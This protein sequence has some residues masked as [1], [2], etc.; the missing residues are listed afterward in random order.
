MRRLACVVVLSA[1]LVA[2]CGSHHP[3]FSWHTG[4]TGQSAASSPTAS[5]RASSHAAIPP[6]QPA[7][8]LQSSTQLQSDLEAL[9]VAQTEGEL[10]DALNGL[11]QHYQAVAGSHANANDAD[12]QQA[13]SK[14][15]QA[16]ADIQRLADTNAS[17]PNAPNPLNTGA[18]S[19]HATSEP[20]PPVPPAPNPV[21]D[22]TNNE[23]KQAFDQ[24]TAVINHV[25]YAITVNNPSGPVG[26]PFGTVHGGPSYPD[27]NCGPAQDTCKAY[28]LTQTAVLLAFDAPEGGKNFQIG[29]IDSAPTGACNPAYVPNGKPPAPTASCHVTGTAGMTVSITPHWVNAPPPANR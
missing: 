5:S 11:R 26:G 16:L 19:S 20:K 17:D 27:I 15:Q 1:I 12:W 6:I 24:L 25:A 3:T 13:L 21:A 22:I 28:V 8:Q 10:V 4:Q 2:G 23:I 14:L 18:S 29:T 9:H 7:Q